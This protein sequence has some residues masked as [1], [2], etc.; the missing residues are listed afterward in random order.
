M[1]SPRHECYTL[2]EFISVPKYGNGLHSAQLGHVENHPRGRESGW[3]RLQLYPESIENSPSQ[4]PPD[5]FRNLNTSDEDRYCSTLSVAPFRIIVCSTMR[6]L[7]TTW[8]SGLTFR[9][10]KANSKTH[11]GIW[12]AESRGQG[13][14]D[15]VHCAIFGPRS[16][17]DRVQVLCTEGLSW[18][19]VKDGVEVVGFT[20]ALG[21]AALGLQA[22]LTV[23]S[24]LDMSVK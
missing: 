14:A 1:R 21:G 15:I 23:F 6:A 5:T 7:N 4:F 22:S 2:I 24:K 13:L 3:A 12:L 20:F 11:D 9:A 8:A 17:N 18:T 10:S 16:S 19:G